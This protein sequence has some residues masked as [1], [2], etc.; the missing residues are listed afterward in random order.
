M[1]LVGVELSPEMRQI[2]LEYVN[3]RDFMAHLMTLPVALKS[4]HAMTC[5]DICFGTLQSNESYVAAAQACMKFSWMASRASL[6]LTRILEIMSSLACGGNAE[7]AERRGTERYLKDL[8]R[9]YAVFA[10]DLCIIVKTFTCISD[11]L[12]LHHDT[13]GALSILQNQ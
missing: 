9:T 2:D 12:H 10:T 7:L 3:V 11:H 5:T 4:R 13:L 6:I 1:A 8:K